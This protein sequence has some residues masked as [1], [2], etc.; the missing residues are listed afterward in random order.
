MSECWH[1]IR[2][3]TISDGTITGM[4]CTSNLRLCPLGCVES[5]GVQFYGIDAATKRL[6]P[7][8]K[9]VSASLKSR[10]SV[11]DNDITILVPIIP[12]HSP[13]I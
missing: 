1:Y 4:H 2:F 8:R 3:G 5:N 6:G 12:S 9:V 13:K 7:S 10:R 11:Y